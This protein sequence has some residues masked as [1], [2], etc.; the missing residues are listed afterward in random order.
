MVMVGKGLWRQHW[1]GFECAHWH[2]DKQE[3]V[4]P[5]AVLRGGTINQRE[6]ARTQWLVLYIYIYTMYF[7]QNP[8]RPCTFSLPF[9]PA[10]S[11]QSPVIFSFLSFVITQKGDGAACNTIWTPRDRF[12]HWLL[13]APPAL[14]NFIIKLTTLCHPYTGLFRHMHII[15]RIA[16]YLE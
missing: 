14:Q 3:T 6:G 13:M 9:K 12:L 7:S 1:R 11:V 10:S 5:S 2:K 4:I 15:E 8:T 16:F